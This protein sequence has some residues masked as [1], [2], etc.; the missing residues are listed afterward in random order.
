MTKLLLLK[1]FR[2]IEITLGRIIMMVIAISV[3]LTV[4]SM[5]LYA[6]I[7]VTD[8]VTNGYMS[9]NPASARITIDPGIAPDK[10]EDLTTIA[11]SEPGVIDATMR[12]FITVKIQGKNGQETPL[13]L[14][15]AGINDPM[16]IATFKIEHGSWP[17]PKNGVLLERTTAQFL[18]MK[19]GDSLTVNGFNNK[20]VKLKVT[21]VV[22]DQSLSPANQGQ[23]GDGYISTNSLTYLGK[24]PLLDQLVITVADQ[25][26]Q[27]E[28]SRNRDTIVATV[29]HVVDRLKEQQNL[30]VED[31][32]VPPPYA[33]PHK[34][35]SDTLMS[36][37]LIF[38]ALS[39]FLSAVLI[40]T[41][42]NG[43]LTQHIPQIGILKAI[44]ARSNRI[45]QFYVLMVFFI[46]LTATILSFVPGLVFGRTIARI[47][48]QGSLNMEVTSL[49]VP[50][51]AYGAV[52]VTGVTIPLLMLLYPLLQASG[53]TVREALDEHGIDNQDSITTSFSNWLARFQNMDRTFLMAIRNILRRTGRFLL[54]VGLLATAGAIFIGGINTMKGVDE[55]P[56]TIT[57]TQKWDVEVRIREPIDQNKLITIANQVPGVTR[58]EAWNVVLTGIESP[59]KVTVT[60]AYPDG[61]AS[62]SVN[63]VPAETSML[64]TPPVLEGRWLNEDDTNAIVLPQNIRKTLPEIKIGSDIELSLDGKP[65]TWQVVGIVKELASPACPCIT[66]TRFGQVTGTPGQAN[67]VRVITD[68]HDLETRTK[69]GQ[70][71]SEALDNAG[72][73]TQDARPIDALLRSTKGHTVLLVGLIMAVAIAIGIVGLIGL[74]STMSTNIIERTREFGVMSAIGAPSSTIRRLVILEGVSIA[75]ASC[76]FAIIPT[77]LL[78]ILMGWG[79]GSLFFGAS[80][81]FQISV[82]AVTI[83]IAIII[84]GTIVATLIPAYKASRLTV[85]EALVNI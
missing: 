32:A 79:I 66:Q 16:R 23:Q 33:H 10:V 54:S 43:V 65:T 2:D 5:M 72:V 61:H 4:F 27:T 36:A 55:L 64:N 51:W 46:A 58:A 85:R 68:K 74:G 3:S 7:L 38:G 57:K 22:H 62:M 9:T 8:Q 31:V 26:G 80:V 13:R 50:W 11:K 70:A 48:L 14:Y 45:L 20:P 1:L 15:T 60:R 28:Q 71:V 12:S 83:W 78:T 29:L 47:I 67:L 42:L 81:P 37:L 39:L 44:G 24:E 73:K 25:A 76:I 19:V 17:P 63:A 56:Q 84:I 18:N 77:F 35:Q 40:A 75:V 69:I 53:R 49:V 34:G 6:R 21:G 52:V 82:T 30:V 59:G 41:I